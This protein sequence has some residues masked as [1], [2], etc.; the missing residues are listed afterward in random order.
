MHGRAARRVKTYG[1]LVK[2]R[3]LPPDVRSENGPF[4]PDTSFREYWEPGAIDSVENTPRLSLKN[5]VLLLVLFGTF[6]DGVGSGEFR[7]VQTGG[8]HACAA[9]IFV[10]A[11][12]RYSRVIDPYF[13]V[14]CHIFYEGC[15]FLFL[16]TEQAGFPF[17][18]IHFIP[19]DPHGPEIDELYSSKLNPIPS[20]LMR[21]YIC[22]A[23][24]SEQHRY[25]YRFYSDDR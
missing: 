11:S 21:I 9:A 7:S 25:F 17:H 13:G 2:L 20:L 15:L 12:S 3:I 18:S 8:H 23:C 4:R 10:Y 14:G 5:F 19:G 6:Q 16:Y 22:T 1:I 24:V